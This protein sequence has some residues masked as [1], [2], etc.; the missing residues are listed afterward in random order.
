MKNIAYVK[1]QNEISRD[2]FCISF[3]NNL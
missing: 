3:L 2:R 1:F